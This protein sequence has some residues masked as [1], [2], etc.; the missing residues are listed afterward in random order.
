MGTEHDELLSQLSVS[1]ATGGS[2]FKVSDDDWEAIE[3]AA[4]G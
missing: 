3:Q 2:V 1:R 4:G